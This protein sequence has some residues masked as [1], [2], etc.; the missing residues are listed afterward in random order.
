M[1][2]AASTEN[3]ELAQPLDYCE[4]MQRRMTKKEG[5]G[6]GGGN[7][8]PAGKSM[9]PNCRCYNL[10][11]TCG[12]APLGSVHACDLCSEHS[13]SPA[14][15]CHPALLDRH[16]LENMTAGLEQGCRQGA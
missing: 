8:P 3:R 2:V 5:E 14:P 15:N 11:G 12:R 10:E 6:E 9:E 7:M 16:I 4:A 13:K 1:P